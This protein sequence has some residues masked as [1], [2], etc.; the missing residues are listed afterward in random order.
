MAGSDV[1]TTAGD[2]IT[3]VLAGVLA[4]VSVLDPIERYAAWRADHSIEAEF[5]V[6][7]QEEV[8]VAKGV[9]RAGAARSQFFE[10]VAGGE[11]ERMFQWGSDT[12]YEF[13]KD[14]VY[15]EAHEPAHMAGPPDEAGLA[16]QLFF[17]VF[18]Q[19]PDLTWLLN[20]EG[21]TPQKPEAIHGTLCDV[22]LGSN[23]PQAGAGAVVTGH[24]VHRVWI[25]PVGR[26]LQ[27]EYTNNSPRGTRTTTFRF[28]K[29]GL[30]SWGLR[31]LPSPKEGTVPLFLPRRGEGIELGSKPKLTSWWNDL[32]KEVEPS[33]LVGKNG[34]IVLFTR[35]DCE[36]TRAGRDLWQVLSDEAKKAGLSFTEVMLSDV[37]ALPSPP[38]PRFWDIKGEIE[39]QVA[40]LGTPYL[41]RLGR[42][43]TALRAWYGY[44]QGEDA[45]ILEA[46]LK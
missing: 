10:M 27:W 40:P 3:L 20:Q 32:R 36:P 23:A 1:K 15:I 4:Q 11:T 8:K 7:S 2:P 45:E 24:L 28:T 22:M 34:M 31:A 16:E 25:D 37:R 9:Y 26:I 21:W 5:S 38:W 44:S 35:P 33:S 19:R 29:I 42:D 18:L 6:E 13:P 12:L 39:N 30:S 46:L 41:L 14:A 43:G 17:P